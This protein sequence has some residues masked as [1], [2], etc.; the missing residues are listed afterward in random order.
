V[1]DQ[2]GWHRTLRVIVEQRGHTVAGAR[3]YWQ[4]E[5]LIDDQEFDFAVIDVNLNAH[6]LSGIDLVAR[7]KSKSPDTRVLVTTGFPDHRTAARAFRAGADD[8]GESTF[9]SVERFLDGQPLAEEQP[10]GYPTL[11][12]VTRDLVHRVYNDNDRNQ[13]ATA[14]ALGIAR[15]SL[16]RLIKK[17]SL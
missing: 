10:E 16:Q 12:A 14:R 4:A 9:E 5:R 1:E 3:N 6:E 2:E 7:I 15:S 11:E 17:Y 13:V 8:F